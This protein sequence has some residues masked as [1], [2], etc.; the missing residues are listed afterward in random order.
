MFD[1]ILDPSGS[2]F[3]AWLI[4][5]VPVALLLFLLAVLRLS[6]WLAVLIGSVATYAI[7]VFVWRMPVGDGALAY[8]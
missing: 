5:L 4:A 1:Q 7:A 6:A 8:L 3:L 2:L